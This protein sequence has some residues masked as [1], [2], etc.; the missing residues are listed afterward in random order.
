MHTPDLRSPIARVHSLGSARS[1]TEVF[2]AQRLTA[3]ALIPLIIWFMVS[4]LSL[5]GADYETVVAWIRAPW[6]TVFLILLMLILFYHALLG[7]KEVIQDYVHHEIL[8]TI[9]IVSMQ[10][11]VITIALASVLAILRIA[12]GGI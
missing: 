6:V 8:K 7:L 11:F 2:V 10:F 4:I 12:L 5:V 1:G 9:T 3:I